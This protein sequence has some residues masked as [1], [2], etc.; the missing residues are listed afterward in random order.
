[1]YI[2]ILNSS[3]NNLLFS[4]T[5][6]KHILIKELLFSYKCLAICL[7]LQSAIERAG[8]KPEEIDE[9]FMGHVC[10]VNL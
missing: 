8:L 3:D 1:M 2:E 6:F 10:Q 7:L 5:S 4:Y 9:V